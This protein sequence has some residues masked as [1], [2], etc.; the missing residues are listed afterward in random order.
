MEDSSSRERSRREEGNEREQGWGGSREDIINGERQK[1][2]GWMRR[3]GSDAG[4]KSF[5]EKNSKMGIMKRQ[6]V[7][8]KVEDARSWEGG[9]RGGESHKGRNRKTI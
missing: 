1:T 9:G 6:K 3:K 4:W 2:T 7:E 8:R 5:T